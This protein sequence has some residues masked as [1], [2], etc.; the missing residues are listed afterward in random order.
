MHPQ[1]TQALST[2]SG[3]RMSVTSLDGKTQI[4]IDTTSDEETHTKI[5][6]E[7]EIERWI[8]MLIDR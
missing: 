1:A 8:D 6:R 5:L 4:K 2:S 3:W 7:N